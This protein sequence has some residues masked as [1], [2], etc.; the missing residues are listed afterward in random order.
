M[1]VSGMRRIIHLDMD[2]FFAAI[3]QLDNPSYRGKPVIVGGSPHA[4]GVVSTC[5]YEARKYG[6]HSAMPLRE[7]ARR[8]PHGIFVPGRMQRYQ[9]VSAAIMQLLREYTPLVEPLSCDEA[10][11]DVTGSEQLFGPAEAIARQIVDRIASELKL[12]A[13]VGVAP[14]KFLAK[15]ASDLKKPRGFVVIGEEEVLSFLAPLPIAR[16]WGVGPKTTAQLKKMGLKTIGDLQEL[17]L[18][19]LRDNLGDLGIHLYHLARGIDDRP[20]EPG[21]TVK[22]IGH[23]TTFQE[24][25]ADREFLEGILWR[26]SEKVARRLRRQGLVGKV[27]TLKMRDQDFQTVTRRSTLYQATDFEEVIFQTARQ[28]AEENAWGRKPLRLIGVSVSGLQTRE[29]SQEPL[30]A[31]ADDEDLRSLH[32]TLDRIRDRFGETA[33]TRARFLK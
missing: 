5:S 17:S 22:S 32:Q 33:I 25:T 23:E 24:D 30:F 9:E 14:N 4:R 20:V 29:N 11:L 16:I 28:L 1:E 2:A 18:T 8:C 31:A 15:L 12:S 26:L 7:A 27:I 13:S 6:I 3:E 19:Y 10:F 21:Q